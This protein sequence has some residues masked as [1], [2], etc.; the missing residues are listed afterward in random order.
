MMNQEEAAYP[1]VSHQTCGPHFHHATRGVW[2]S[3]TTGTM[4][5]EQQLTDRQSTNQETVLGVT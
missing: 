4:T 1:L 2:T 3:F 5:L